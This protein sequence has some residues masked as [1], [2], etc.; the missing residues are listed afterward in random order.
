MFRNCFLA[1]SAMIAVVAGLTAARA[2]DLPAAAPVEAP[3][4]VATSG[5]YIGSRNQ[6]TFVQETDFD[7]LGGIANVETDYE[8]GF[9]AAGLIGYDF[10]T[11]LGG[12][13]GVRVELEGGYG[14]SSV[15]TH[16]LSALGLSVEVDETDSFGELTTIAGFGNLF[17]DLNFGDSLLKPFIGGGVGAANVELKK[18]G[19]SATGVLMDDDDIALAYHGSAGVGIDLG[20]LGFGG[21]LQ[22]ATL[23]IG[24]RY[25]AADDLSFTA[26]EDTESE[27][28]L[29]SHNITFG[30]RSSF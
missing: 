12:F 18:Q 15:E 5:F 19:I 6:V 4:T 23:E 14:E 3:V 17:L 21:A 7:L 10:G 8:T 20:R 24:Y 27:T 9:F 13:A 29:D 11:I 28:D 1:T 25:M 16:T 30:I 26:R 22:G 2:A